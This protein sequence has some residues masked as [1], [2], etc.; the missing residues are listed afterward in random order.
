MR[1]FYTA[2]YNAVLTSRAH[3]QFCELAYG[4]DLNQ[5][6]FLTMDA[7]TFLLDV[8]HWSASDRILDIGCGSGKITEHIAK[9]TGAN[10]VG[11]DYIPEALMYAQERTQ[12]MLER[13]NFFVGDLTCLP[14]MSHSFDALLSIDTLY[15]SSDYGTTLRQWADRLKE[16]GHLVIFYSYGA[17]PEYPKESFD[18]A[19]LAPDKNPL[20][21][22][23]TMNG[24][25]FRTWDFTTADYVL[26]QRKHEVL[27]TLRDSF[28]AEG[29]SFLYENRIGESEG[30]L[31]AARSGMHSRFLYLVTP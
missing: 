18:T 30:I 13:L 27:E 9:A 2:F 14:C 10:V 25:Q 28:K 1:A 11:M 29:N 16:G 4:K 31:E 7:L 19:T 17:S 15:F 12:V 22:A 23:L 20:G 21:R 24:L 26:A 3:A 6:G 5:H 8:M